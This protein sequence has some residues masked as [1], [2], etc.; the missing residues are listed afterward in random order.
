M[1]LLTLLHAAAGNLGLGLEAAHLDHGLRADSSEDADFVRELCQRLVLPLSCERRDVAAIANRQKG[2]LE[3]VARQERYAFLRTVAQ[4]RA[5]EFVALG[6][7]RNDQAETFLMHLLRG[8]GIT[9]LAGMRPNTGLFLRPLL[10]FD[11]E[12]LRAYLREKDLGW[13][14]DPTNADVGLTRNRIRHE[15]LPLLHQ[16]N[17]QIEN[18]LSVLCERFAADESYWETETAQLLSDHA[19]R[20]VGGL[21]LPRKLLSELPSA[22]AGRLVRAALKAVRGDLRRFESGHVG[23]IL[24]LAASRKPQAELGMPEC[25]VA[26]RYKRLLICCHPPEV[27]DPA[28]VEIPEEGIYPL[29]DGRFLRVA[30]VDHSSGEGR[31]TVEF[32]AAKVAFPL[33]VRTV[34]PGDRLAPA[35]MAGSKKLQDFFV[36]AKLTHEERAITPLVVRG[37]EILWV[38]GMRRCRDYRPEETEEQVLRLSVGV[39]ADNQVA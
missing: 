19:E 9:G 6:H 25:W 36:D 27:P 2:N 3:E 8:T 5:C 21:A 24:R 29:P 1:A 12:E 38:V 20:I 22:A 37:S 34:R 39:T 7:H 4:N 33:L 26:V 14:E 23:S 15:L 32:S 13:R 28:P 35:G 17:P 16:F 31:E 10:G 11:R 30:L 18:R